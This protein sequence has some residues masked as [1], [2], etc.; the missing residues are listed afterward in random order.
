MRNETFGAFV[1]VTNGDKTQE[2]HMLP[3]KIEN[4]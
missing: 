1:R 4:C 3:T 2:Q